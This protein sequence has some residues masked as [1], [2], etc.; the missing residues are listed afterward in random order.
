MEENKKVDEVYDLIYNNLR[1]F[2]NRY[3]QE[4]K[5]LNTFLITFI[6]FLITTC[7]V[8]IASSDYGCVK[9]IFCLSISSFII[10]ALFHYLISKLEIDGY[11]KL[12]D[13]YFKLYQSDLDTIKWCVNNEKKK[14]VNKKEKKWNLYKN[15]SLIIW[16]LLFIVWL[17]IYSL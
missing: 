16:T 8:L 4:T 9:V 1:F 17:F 5:N 13:D 11:S 6:W 10:W 14:I 12:I 2:E 15:I 7:W 3:D